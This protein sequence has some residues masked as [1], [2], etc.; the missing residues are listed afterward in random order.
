[1]VVLVLYY[2][3]ICAETLVIY[4]PSFAFGHVMGK[5]TPKSK[6]KKQYLIQ[7]NSGEQIG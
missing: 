1:V 2:F 6:N 4:K 7:R 3:F 5:K